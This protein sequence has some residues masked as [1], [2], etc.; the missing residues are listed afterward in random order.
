MRGVNAKSQKDRWPF[1]RAEDLIAEVRSARLFTTIDLKGEFNYVMLHLDDRHKT[2][3]CAGRIGL[4]Q[5]KRPSM[6][7]QLC[8]LTSND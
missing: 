1:L 3:F 2:C 5:Y 7:W 6:G 4:G 8:H